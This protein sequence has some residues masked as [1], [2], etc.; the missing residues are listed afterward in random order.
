M[1]K[2]TKILTGLLAGVAIGTAIALVLS[3]DKN[4]EF[5]QKATDWFCDLLDSSKD[6]LAAVT[7]LVKDKVAKVNV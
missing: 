4:D 5:K 2:Q 1:T 6:K 7:G 3:S